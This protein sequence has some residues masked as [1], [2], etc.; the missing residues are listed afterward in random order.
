MDNVYKNCP[1]KMEDG[2]LFTDYRMANRREQHIK[3]INNLTRDDEQRMYYM[4]N[5]KKIADNEWEYLK[6]NKS[7]FNNSCVHVY[8]TRVPPGS[9]NKEINLYNSVRRGEQKAPCKQLDDYRLT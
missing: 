9:Y 6:K 4:N 1:P 8:P 7:C 2:R 5:A 3:Y